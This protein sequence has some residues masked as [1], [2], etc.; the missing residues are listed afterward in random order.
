MLRIG[1]TS[2]HATLYK[3]EGTNVLWVNNIIDGEFDDAK[4]DFME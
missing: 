2:P 4:R 1:I 3:G